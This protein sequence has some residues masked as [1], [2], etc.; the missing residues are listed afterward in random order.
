MLDVDARKYGMRRGSKDSESTVS[1]SARS[2]MHP[3][4]MCD[5]CLEYGVVS[6]E[7]KPHCIWGFFPQRRTSLNI[8]EEKCQ[9]ALWRFDHDASNSVLSE[10]PG[11]RRFVGGS[12]HGVGGASDRLAGDGT[13]AAMRKL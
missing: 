7:R 8:S 10:P 6:G 9:R 13:P 12:N 5:D 4:M 2:D 1:L 11:R 3:A